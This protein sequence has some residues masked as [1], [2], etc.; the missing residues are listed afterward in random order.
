MRMRMALLVMM[1]AALAV[2]GAQEKKAA[3]NAKPAGMPKAKQ[4]AEMAKA[5]KMFAGNWVL[6]EKFEAMPEMGMPQAAT[7][8][9]METT[10]RGP[11]GNSL[12]SDMK[13]TSSQGPFTGHGVM[14]YDP[15]A[16]GYQATWCDSDSPMGCMLNGTGKWQGND[17]VFEFDAPMPPEMGGGKMHMRESYTDIKSDSFTFSIATGP[18]ASQ[19]KPMMTIKYKRAGK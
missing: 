11:G 3:T 16:G 8:K 9:G 12:I 7:G 18:N 4:S 14:W 10:K 13:S 17:L 5:E 19:M 2:A 15:M 1:F 6:D